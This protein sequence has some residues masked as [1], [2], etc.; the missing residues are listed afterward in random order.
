MLSYA[1]RLLLRPRAL[2][3]AAGAVATTYSHRRIGNTN[4]DFKAHKSEKSG[5]SIATGNK[6]LQLY[7]AESSQ[8][9]RI[10]LR[11]EL[12]FNDL[13]H[14]FEAAG[15][16]PKDLKKMFEMMDTDGSNTV[17]FA[18]IIA[19]FC[20]NASGTLNEKASFFFQSCD[21]DGSGTIEKSEL[22]TV[23]LHMMALR[24]ETSGKASFFDW[25]QTLYADIPTTYVLHLQANEF[26][27][28][29]FSSVS[30]D[31]EQLTEKE[32]QKWLLRGGKQVNRLNALFSA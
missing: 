5:V 31:G 14:L 28:D 23:V 30:K 26:V 16:R 32:F 6:L 10:D 8:N 7:F 21:V 22:K 20:R 19:F 18:E 17:D 11:K 24:N 12:S 9:G 4:C 3:C 13:K 27:N 1:T 15:G 25:N 2:L 29:V